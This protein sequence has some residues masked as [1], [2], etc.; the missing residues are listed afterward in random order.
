MTKLAIESL[1]K[2]MT[3]LEAKRDQHLHWI[4]YHEEELM[5]E[6][7]N[8]DATVEQIKGLAQTIELLEKV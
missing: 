6:R 5:K 1:K 7:L 3:G 2:T 8:Y 4:G